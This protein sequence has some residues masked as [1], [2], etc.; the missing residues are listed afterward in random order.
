MAES[1]VTLKRIAKE[2]KVSVTTVSRVLRDRGEISDQTRRHVLSVAEK[3]RYRPNFGA[4][5][6]F[7]GRTDSVGVIMTSASQFDARISFGIHDS[8][9][10]HDFVP[11]TLWSSSAPAERVDHSVVLEQIHQLIDRRVDAFI[12]RPDFDSRQAYISEIWER[13]VPLV[14]VDRDLL[15]SH[16]DFVGTDDELGAWL[17]ADHLLS[18]GHRNIVHIAGPDSA[19]TGRI[20]RRFFEAAIAAVPDAVCRTIIDESFGLDGGIVESLFRLD[21]MPTAVFAANDFIA[22]N[23]YRKARE[24]SLRIP[25]DLSVI[26]YA[27]LEFASFLDP[28]LTTLRQD[29]YQLGRIAGRM[30]VERITQKKTGHE[31][32]KVVLKPQLIIRASTADRDMRL[33]SS[34]APDVSG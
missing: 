28:P 17:A 33:K 29:P 12:L 13:D 25:E 20:R 2:A 14:T 6:I 18:L 21:P 32:R 4:R 16:S 27:D 1:M 11:I 19:T 5:S 34:G 23:L 9:A 31:H 3:L 15:E 24:R 10:E 7:T 8:L 30:A 22:A 26:G